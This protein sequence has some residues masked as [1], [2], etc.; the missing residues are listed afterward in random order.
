[1]PGICS[2][3][4]FFNQRLPADVPIDP[5]SAAYVASLAAQVESAGPGIE[6]RDF[7]LTGWYA[8]AGTPREKVWLDAA[9]G[10]S[11]LKR[12]MLESIPLPPDLRPPGP[13][14]GDNAVAIV[15]YSTDEY[16]ELHGMR[17]KGVDA[18]RPE[19]E[20]P[21]CS[22]LNEPGWHCNGAAG[23]KDFSE[24]PGYWR[25]GDWPGATANWGISGSGIFVWPGA[26]K[27]AEA[28]GLYIPHAIRIEAIGK[29]S[30]E[31]QISDEFRWPATKTDGESVDPDAPKEGMIFR[32]PPAFVSKPEDPFIRAVA[33]AVNE[34]GFIL[35]DGAQNVSIKCE[36]QA[37]VPRSQAYTT[38]AW[39]GPADS[40]G[41]KGAILSTFAKALAEQFP[42]A[43]L[44]VVDPSYRPSS[45]APGGVGRGA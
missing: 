41:S 18:M 37:T 29:S 13:F 22:T 34:Y 1:M 27:I 2:P 40:F 44:E 21:G 14:P 42:W 7:A 38:D 33:R 30:G 23:V 9:D 25:S 4:S 39:K 32:L 45:I 19:A 31:S 11:P 5:S 20:V 12:E 8:G 24:S 15:S 26:I 17:F 6:F 36:S 10:T 35:T 3:T 16:F 28:Q 43:N